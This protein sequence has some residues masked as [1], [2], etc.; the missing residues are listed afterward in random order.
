MNAA[1][2]LQLTNAFL[3]KCYPDKLKAWTFGSSFSLSKEHIEGLRDCKWDGRFQV[4]FLFSVQ[5]IY[6]PTIHR[7]KLYNAFLLFSIILDFE[8]VK[9]LNLLLGRR[10]YNRQS[11]NYKR[12]VLG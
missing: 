2:A 11:Y 7:I 6:S 3:A 12:M 10:T 1:L 8:T 9:I 4:R 5:L